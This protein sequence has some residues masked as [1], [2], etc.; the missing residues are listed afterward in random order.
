MM[1]VPIEVPQLGADDQPLRLCGW[2]VDVGDLVVKGDQI[3][4]VVIPGVTFGIAS[5]LT[6]RLVEITCQVDTR[7][8]SGSI[9]GWVEPVDE[10]IES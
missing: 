5:P 10:L 3:A 1:R 9:L 6:G 7:I 8:Q 2:L 4:E